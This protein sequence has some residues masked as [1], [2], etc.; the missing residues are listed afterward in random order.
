MAQSKICVI[1][2]LKKNRD[3]RIS[4]DFDANWVEL[5][6][7]MGWIWNEGLSKKG[8]KMPEKTWPL[9]GSNAEESGSQI[10]IYLLN[11][12]VYR[13]GIAVEGLPGTFHPT[14]RNWNIFLHPC[15]Q[16]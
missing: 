11:I 3:V 1:E 12:K 7:E 6:T 13:A 9:P 10:T 8:F 5:L 14:R 4:P 15:N 16:I 2:V